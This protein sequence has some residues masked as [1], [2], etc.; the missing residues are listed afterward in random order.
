MEPRVYGVLCFPDLGKYPN[1]SSN[2]WKKYLQSFPW[3]KRLNAGLKSY[4]FL[5]EKVANGAAVFLEVALVMFLGAV[6]RCGGRYF[7]DNCFFVFS[8]GLKRGL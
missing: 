5:F 4:F 7:R 1:K 8:G 2:P 6:E 3:R